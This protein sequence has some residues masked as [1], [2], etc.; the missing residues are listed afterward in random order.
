MRELPK[1]TTMKKKNI[2]KIAQELKSSKPKQK[3]RK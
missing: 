2:V 1:Q 3:K